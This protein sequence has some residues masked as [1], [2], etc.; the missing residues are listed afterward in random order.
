MSA[1]FLPAIG[2]PPSIEWVAPA[3][4]L[5]DHSY[6]RSIDNTASQK[7][8]ATIARAWD[9]RL[10]V[11]LLL[12]RRAD[13]LYVID[14]QH[15]AE[16]AKRRSDVPF[17]PCCIGEYA[18][19]TEEAETFIASNAKRCAVS[20]FDQWRAALLAGDAG[21]AAI[22]Q[23][24]AHA[25]LTLS[26][27]SL[28]GL[29]PGQINA[30]GVVRTA[31]ARHGVGTAGDALAAIATAF[32][33]V[34]VPNLGAFLGAACQMIEIDHIGPDAIAA[35]L[36]GRTVYAWLDDAK[37]TPLWVSGGEGTTRAM[38]NVLR[39]RTSGGP[40]LTAPAVIARSTAVPTP[41]RVA[42][43]LAADDAALKA[44]IHADIG[45]A[46]MAHAPRCLTSF[47]KMSIDGT[48]ALAKACQRSG[49]K[50]Q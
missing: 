19:T 50:F 16:G 39:E 15:R 25:G 42:P 2:A 3:R 29:K 17:L 44:A 40:R 43:G 46:P 28:N 41:A 30:L 1:D 45:E 8:I 11:P 7:L 10:C 48:I 37:A 22:A 20:R 32:P 14:G 33:E 47:E 6:Q 31:I 21:A 36:R 34:V 23:V 38:R 26:G 12:S 35:L 49:G 4:L 18:S 5:V 9:W 27:A 13:G 24:V